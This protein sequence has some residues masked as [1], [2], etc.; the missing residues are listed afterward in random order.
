[1]VFP[2][3]VAVLVLGRA[4][5]VMLL[6]AVKVGCSMS[7]IWPFASRCTTR[8]VSAFLLLSLDPRA[9]VLHVAHT[10]GGDELTRT[11]GG[12]ANSS[13]PG[14]DPRKVSRTHFWLIV[15][16]FI[17]IF[18]L[19]LLQ[20]FVLYFSMMLDAALHFSL[21]RL[22]SICPLFRSLWFWLRMATLR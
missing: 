2:P 12:I 16:S 15:G 17:V 7:W 6:V 1:M 4:T 3:S 9:P 14:V 20:L 19:L 18:W 13:I 21:E 10:Q 5:A 8:C 11:L 22:P